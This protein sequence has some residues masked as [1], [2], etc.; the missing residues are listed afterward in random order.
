MAAN[1]SK[2][3][4][5]ELVRAGRV[6]LLCGNVIDLVFKKNREPWQIKK[7]LSALQEFK[8]SRSIPRIRKGHYPGHSVNKCLGCGGFINDGGICQCG[9]DHINQV[10]C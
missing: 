8:D 6:I 4:N 7:L 9:W 2:E 1:T 10:C 5:V 3:K